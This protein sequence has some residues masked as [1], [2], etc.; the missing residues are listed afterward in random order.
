M[1]KRILCPREGCEGIIAHITGTRMVS[2]KRSN[3]RFQIIGS[4]YSLI[5]TCPYSTC[6]AEV[7]IIC[8]N[9]IIDETLLKIEKQDLNLDNKKNGEIKNN[10]E[11]GTGE[12]GED[13]DK[14]K[15]NKKVKK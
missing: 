11:G 15:K 4:D 10:I 6:P 7:S 8:K 2:I 12:S 1:L 5:A 3:Q 14:S 13:K 9:G